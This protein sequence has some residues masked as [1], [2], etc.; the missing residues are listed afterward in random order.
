MRGLIQF[1][2]AIRTL[3]IACSLP[4]GLDFSNCFFAESRGLELHRQEHYIARIRGGMTP[5]CIVSLYSLTPF[6]KWY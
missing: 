4:Q 1:N 5:V 2:R 3:K 6:L